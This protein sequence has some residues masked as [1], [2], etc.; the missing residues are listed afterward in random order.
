MSVGVRRLAFVAAAG[1]A[2]VL[3]IWVISPRFA[4][5]DLSLV[6]DWWLATFSDEVTRALVHLD[7]DPDAIGDPRRYRPTHVGVW[8]YLVW[9]T[10]GAPASLVGPNLWNLLR[11]ALFV[12][13][14]A[15]LPLALAGGE[16][17][18]RDRAAVALAAAVPAVVL[19]TPAL[20]VEFA[21]LGTAEPFLV[22]GMVSG[23]ALVLLGARRSLE[24][25]GASGWSLAWPWLAGVPLWLMGVYHKETSVCFLAGAPFLYLFLAERWRSP[26]ASRAELLTR[27]PFQVAAAVLLLPVLHMTYEVLTLGFG[28]VSQYGIEAPSS[29]SGLFRRLRGAFGVQS[30]FMGD[31]LGTPL[32][33][34]AA[35]AVTIA[36]ALIAWRRRRVQWLPLGLVCIAWAVFGFGGL[37]GGG[38]AARYF[39]PALA[40]FA[41][42]GALLVL[43]EGR[44]AVV[45]VAL[46]AV[47]LVVLGAGD[48]RGNVELWAERVR[49][50]TRAVDAVAA[51]DPARCRIYLGRFSIESADALP[52]L[53]ARERGRRRACDARFAG[54][55]V[56]GNEPYPVTDDRVFDLCAEPGWIPLARAGKV[57]LLG[58]PRFRPGAASR[59]GRSILAADRLVPGVRYSERR[60][61]LG[62]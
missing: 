47:A 23:G 62:R 32:W 53:V 36:V 41:L 50:E 13:P 60:A 3:G 1:S 35:L 46:G 44:P 59:L 58:C 18:R 52:I 8:S 38:V 9:H 31:V 28:G 21:R 42:A 45:P 40:L 34:P 51:L 7:Y 43:E 55:L 61:A 27:R 10:L 17:A 49:A 6:D 11:L 39:V 56:D 29:A 15:A 14:L 20:G 5:P 24:R 19:A 26:G 4:I 22:G 54:I 25:R 57:D 12:V 37:A 33:R 48:S 16:S 2:V 30:H